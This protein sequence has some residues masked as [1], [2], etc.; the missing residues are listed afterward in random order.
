MKENSGFKNFYKQA[1]EL[2]SDKFRKPY[3]EEYGD[4]HT[5]SYVAYMITALFGVLLF[6]LY[7][8]FALKTLNSPD[9][10]DL[11]CH[12]KFAS[13]FYLKWSNFYEAWLR[14]PYCLWHFCV[15]FFQCRMGFPWFEAASFVYAWFGIFSYIVS[16]LF[17]YKLV[18]FYTKK[19]HLLFS[20]LASFVLSTVGPYSMNWFSDS[21]YGQFSPNPFHNPTHM[22]VK[23]FGILLVMLGIDIVRKLKKEELIFFKG[24]RMFL[25]FGIIL[26]LSTVTKPTF[27]FMLLPTGFLYLAGQAIYNAVKKQGSFKEALLVFAK[28]VLA[29]IP[30]L[31]YLGLEMFAFYSGEG[32][33]DAD[34]IVLSGFLEI[35]HMFSYDVP[36]SVLLAMFFPIWMVV[37]N[38]GYFFRSTE[39]LMSLLCYVVGT[40]E[41][42]FI[43]ESGPQADSANFAWCMMAGMVVLYGVSIAKLVIET[44]KKNESK[45]HGIYIM[46][47]WFFLF[48]HVYS[49]LCLTTPFGLIF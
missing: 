21:Y 34:G 33:R 3:S 25:W 7:Y 6:V 47:S 27:M 15:K 35:W 20:T 16:A 1:K 17:I 41:F 29:S 5:P 10:T 37:T 4:T 45:A 30:S 22:A 26:F 12:V 36:T 13:D 38:P 28:F 43:A 31:L 9:I 14:M 48:M 32:H 18:K 40:L 46:L 23:P 44:I 49:G 19:E 24:K 2:I 11:S 39:G 42:S 8:L